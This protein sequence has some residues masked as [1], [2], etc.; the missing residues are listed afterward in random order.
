MRVAVPSRPALLAQTSDGV[1]PPTDATG[2]FLGASRWF[3]C[4]HLN[5]VWVMP[6]GGDAVV[7]ADP[8][9]LSSTGDVFA[10]PTGN[11]ANAG[12]FS[13]PVLTLA[14]AQTRLREKIA[15]NPN[16]SY[17]AV[18]LG[19][20]Y[21]LTSTLILTNADTV[22]D[23]F[24]VTWK[25]LQGSN[26]TI[27]GGIPLTGFT[28]V[29]GGKW[30]MNLSTHP[31][32]SALWA[33]G[34]RP[35]EL[36]VND[37]PAEWPCWPAK[38]ATRNAT[39]ADATSSWVPS[40]GDVIATT[41]RGANTQMDNFATI[42]RACNVFTVQ[43]STVVNPT[44]TNLQDVRLRVNCPG[45]WFDSL[46]PIQS[47]APSGGHIVVTLNSHAQTAGGFPTGTPVRAENV[48]EKGVAG[49]SYVNRSTG[50][51]TYWPR[52]G[53]TLGA[54][55]IIA[56]VLDEFIT[57]SMARREGGDGVTEVGKVEF[58]NLT[59]KHSH[60]FTE[61]RGWVGE[62][63]DMYTTAHS[64]LRMVGAHDVDI[65]HC[66]FD[67]IGEG[68]AE[69]AHGSYNNKFRSNN[70][71]NIG[72]GGVMNT[73][74]GARNHARYPGGTDLPDYLRGI[75][76]EG[77][78][79]DA[80]KQ[81]QD[82]FVFQDND[83]IDFGRKFKNCGAWVSREGRD[84]TVSNNRL[85][86]FPCWGL[87]FYGNI[88]DVRTN[89][90]QGR[91]AIE[92]NWIENGNS[93][94]R[95]PGQAHSSDSSPLYVSGARSALFGDGKSTH[96][97]YNICR[98]IYPA[99]YPEN[100]GL[101][102]G[103]GVA[104][105]SAAY[106]DNYTSGTEY[107]YNVYVGV[108][109]SMLT[110]KGQ[111][112]SFHDNIFIMDARGRSFGFRDQTLKPYFPFGDDV[113]EVLSGHSFADFQRNVLVITSDQASTAGLFP[114]GLR[115][116]FL[117]QMTPVTST[118]QLVHDYNLIHQIGGVNAPYPTLDADFAAW[119]TATGQDIH[120]VLQQDPL[121]TDPANL[122]FSFPPES[123]LHGIGFTG[124]PITAGLLTP[125]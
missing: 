51:V 9:S 78:M 124:F 29:G 19:G 88:N 69:F 100:M 22:A 91:W 97:R 77:L 121:F 4:R 18:L 92:N 57:I 25:A 10:S 20:T 84:F 1:T 36:F 58:T 115:L 2:V 49:D 35:T 8:Y 42:G 60:S 50:V 65:H 72:F 120:T 63:Q 114:Q 5:Y 123:P 47:A 99:A 24:K 48:F 64:I 53:E 59:F 80:Y 26:A 34:W 95:A 87:V 28:D 96:F 67:L 79:P 38:G 101:A 75:A 85:R 52:V 110:Y 66:T 11:D 15:V 74:E 112:N 119:R 104:Y 7:M 89:I 113:S 82:G 13:S 23:G 102:G 14:G 117:N 109:S 32:T 6:L 54:A 94:R 86:H 33:G 27:S 116:H 106:L 16:R 70:C 108:S 71:S 76:Y 43:D 61:N 103:E 55:E 31:S 41:D 46:I 81:K 3:P 17:T 12:T 93:E 122:D 39:V 118:G 107:A 111:D 21:P 125:R 56:P 105:W 37:L 44:W 62:A 40:V 98:D 90:Y 30:Q 83:F 68:I 73:G 45:A